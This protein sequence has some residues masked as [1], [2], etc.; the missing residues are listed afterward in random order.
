MKSN[1]SFDFK[2]FQP[3]GHLSE[4]VQ[5]V[6]SASVASNSENEVSQW[7]NS[8]GCS[9]VLLNLGE[10]LSLGDMEFA[11][12]AVLLP[13]SKQTQ[14][15]TL[16]PG[17]QIAGLRFHPAVGFGVLGKHCEAPIVLT[18]ED[19]PLDLMTLYHQLR[20]TKGHH[21]RVTALYRWVNR[22][23]ATSHQ[24]PPTLSLAIQSLNNLHFSTKLDRLTNNI[25]LSQRQLE[26]QF[27]KWMGMTA[28]Q[29]QRILR[30]QKTLSVLKEN[31]DMELVALALSHGFTDQAH[32]TRELKQIAKITPRQYREAVMNAH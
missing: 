13:V 11:A 27:Q 5:A 21:A 17:A 20:H 2:L 29:Y 12:G 28:K 30:V 15:I 14:R 6:W 26:R 32:M 4:S 22:V 1:V 19:A 16:P 8:D 9:G 24:V 25:P 7:L 31:Q 23:V 10:S 3:T 18:M